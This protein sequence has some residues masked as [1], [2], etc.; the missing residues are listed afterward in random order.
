M[1][2]PASD[3]FN[4]ANENPLG[5]GTWA[6]A[7]TAS[8]MVVDTNTCRASASGFCCSFWSADT[9][10]ND[11]YAEGVAPSPNDGGPA[12]RITNSGLNYY[13]GQL[14]AGAL[15]LSK[16][17]N[18]VYT[19]IGSD[20]ILT[21]NSTDVIRL[22]VVGTTFTWYKNGIAQSPTQTDSSLSTGYAGVAGYTTG[23]AS[24]DNW[25][26]G[27]VGGSPSF[28][29]GYTK[30]KKITIDHTKVDATTDI[31]VRVALTSGNFTWADTTDTGFDIQFTSSDGTTLLNFDRDYH[32]KPNSVAEYH[33][34]VPSASSTVDTDFY[35]YFK[36]NTTSRWEY[37]INTD[38]IDSS[39][40][41]TYVVNR[42]TKETN[43][44]F[45]HE[46]VGVALADDGGVF[47]TE[48]TG[49]NNGTANDM[50]L[51][52]AVPAVND[53]YYFGASF[54][55][56]DLIMTV[57]TAGVG[58]WTIVWEYWNGSAWTAVSGLYVPSANFD[59][60][61]VSGKSDIAWNPPSGWATTSVNGISKYWIRARVSAYTSITTQPKGTQAWLTDAWDRDKVYATVLTDTSWPTESRYRMWYMGIPIDKAG[62]A[63]GD[64][65]CSCYA[66]SDTGAKGSWVKPNVG[67]V[68]YRSSTANNM[69]DL[70]NGSDIDSSV[71]SVIYD[72]ALAK[73]IFINSAEYLP[74]IISLREI[75]TSSNPSGPFTLEKSF[76]GSTSVA[77]VDEH[78]HG[79]GIARRGDNR[80]IAYTQWWDGVGRGVG[81][82]VSDTNSLAGTWTDAGGF[83][84]GTSG[85]DQY[86][87]V[88]IVKT[89][90]VYYG[91]GL[92]YDNPS[93]GGPIRL[94]SSRNGIN[95]TDLDST[96]IDRGTS[97]LWDDASVWNPNFLQIGNEWWLYYAG[98]ANNTYPSDG[99]VGLAK[100]GYQ[101]I[102]SIERQSAGEGYVI[103]RPIQVSSDGLYINAIA[104]GTSDKIEI[105]L[106]NASDNSVI[107]GYAKT[108]CTDIT[109]DTYSTEVMWGSNHFNTCTVSLVKIKFYLTKTTNNVKLHAYMIGT[110]VADAEDDSADKAVWGKSCHVYHGSDLTT[111]TMKDS[112]G[113]SRNGTKFSANNPVEATGK[114][115]KAQSFDGIDDFIDYG[116]A[117]N[118]GTANFTIESISKRTTGTYRIQRI[119]DYGQN[120]WYLN[121]SATSIG[122]YSALAGNYLSLVYT[123]TIDNT[124]FYYIAAKRATGTGYLRINDTQ[125]AT[126][127]ISHNITTAVPNLLAG[128]FYY[129]TTNYY[130]PGIGDEFRIWF[131]A[132]SDAWLKA[133]Y[134]S[135]FNTLVTIGA[136]ETS[137]S[138]LANYLWWSGED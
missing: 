119:D 136:T 29:P 47:A 12:L 8:P 36:S 118:L 65:R 25:A 31:K 130:F 86:H 100:I 69:Y 126:G 64:M 42:P 3:N 59:Q 95:F 21:Y 97:G 46:D 35:M 103:S 96:W 68:S 105:E 74:A 81:G 13:W 110:D 50:T 92:N 131:E 107:T 26:G 67:Q 101:R 9:F 85:T 82:F 80:W 109:G 113:R 70:H 127:D 48:T 37:F 71:K 102:N 135:L 24:F 114:I 94:L 6:T 137:I 121:Q 108:D 60:F 84:R 33:V 30:R 23:S 41:M 18:G 28:L 2:L 124:N 128:K 51:L 76:S 55:F 75:Y 122:F 73:F 83:K 57:G 106:L 104:N 54:T 1:A 133:S 99:Q 72:A 132:K 4:R 40:G 34:S 112:G 138:F 16:V 56:T 88:Q 89:G 78:G 123:A 52:P 62:Y 17:V 38:Q 49:C 61:K 11:Q 5:N 20:L 53:A 77:L 125:Q 98:F 10:N 58:T 22:E 27:N 117:I 90:G 134:H 129:A 79:M 19:V 44:I 91:V 120:G 87:D 111:S 45:G 93:G 63:T 115:A 66:Y 7:G 39:S 43:P 15:R 32:D 14:R 116:N